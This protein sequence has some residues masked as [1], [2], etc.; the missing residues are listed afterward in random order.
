MNKITHEARCPGFQNINISNSGG[1]DNNP[2]HSRRIPS[3]AN[4]S[5]NTQVQPQR[6]PLYHVDN[7]RSSTIKIRELIKCTKCNTEVDKA[8]LPNHQKYDCNAE[9]IPCEFCQTLIIS[10]FYQDHVENCPRNPENENQENPNNIMIPCETCDKAFNSQIYEEHVQ[11][12]AGSQNSFKSANSQPEPNY[13]DCEICDEQVLD[14]DYDSHT[15]SHNEQGSFYNQNTQQHSNNFDNIFGNDPFFNSIMNDMRTLSQPESTFMS[16]P[17]RQRNNQSSN[18]LSSL[19][20]QI[21]EETRTDSNGNTR[22]II[23]INPS[24][25]NSQINNGGIEDLVSQIMGFGFLGANGIDPQ[26]FLQSL[27]L[28]ERGLDQETMQGLATVKFNKDKSKNLDEE[29]KKCSVCLTDFEDGEMIKFLP[30]T[31]R[32]H[33]DCIDPWLKDHST[34]PLCKKDFRDSNH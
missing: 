2:N 15:E 23:R 3:K 24:R 9:K 6:A 22:T 17:N 8:N 11:S 21:I 14:S 16:M 5:H 19:G 32:F 25:D 29:S 13:V 7:L 34:C 1:I 27:G 26:E 28:R 20:Q 4:V 31:H 12:C 30:C 33:G 18:I 10:Q